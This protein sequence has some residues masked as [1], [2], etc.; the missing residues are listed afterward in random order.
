MASI[1]RRSFTP[2]KGFFHVLFI[3]N[4]W[5]I[6]TNS[7]RLKCILSEMK[8]TERWWL[9]ACQFLLADLTRSELVDQQGTSLR[10][11]PAIEAIQLSGYLIQL[12]VSVVEL[13]Q[14]LRVRPLHR[15]TQRHKEVIFNAGICICTETTRQLSKLRLLWWLI[16]GLENTLFSCVHCSF[17]DMLFLNISYHKVQ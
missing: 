4:E 1:K 8:G 11:F 12:F 17:T 10:V 5:N 2:L 6:S 9:W 14:E 13:G 3:T 7:N 15:N 16:T